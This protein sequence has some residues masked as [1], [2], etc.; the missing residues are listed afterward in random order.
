[1]TAREPDRRSVLRAGAAITIAGF[2]VSVISGCG[3]GKNSP[4]TQAAAT[5]NELSDPVSYTHL[6]LPTSD[7]V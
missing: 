2:S 1:M 6:T 5:V 4:G 7:L 3:G